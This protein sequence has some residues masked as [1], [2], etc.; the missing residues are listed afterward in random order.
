MK[1]LSLPHCV[2]WEVLLD[3]TMQIANCTH[4][5]SVPS[6]PPNEKCKTL[7]IYTTF[8]GERQGEGQE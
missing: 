4:Q 8:N 1:M 7:A 5:A 6:A 2:E 3:L